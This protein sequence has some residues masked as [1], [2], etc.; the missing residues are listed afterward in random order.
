MD[1]HLAEGGLLSGGERKV[2]ADSNSQC[3]DRRDE[4]IGHLRD[5]IRGAFNDF[6]LLYMV[7]TEDEVREVFGGSDT[8]QEAIRARV[9]HVLAFLYFGLQLTDDDVT[10]RIISA[11]KEAEAA[12]DR[13]A[14]VTLDI[15][16]QPFLS[17]EQQTRALKNGNY[18]QV[19]A[20]AL[21]RLWHDERVSP[22][23]VVAA[24]AALGEEELTVSDVVAEREGAAMIERMPAPVV[25]NVEFD[26]DSTEEV[27]D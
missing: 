21:D 25:T 27:E 2:L 5:R 10:H 1:P 12:N 23:D 16:T 22:T 4:L 17:P 14:S 3:E 6:E 18:E 11:I 19:S 7:L 15:V 13:E 20:E 26:T 8:T 24:F 9:Q